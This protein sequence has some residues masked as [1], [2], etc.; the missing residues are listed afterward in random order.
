MNRFSICKN[1]RCRFVLDR[2]VNGESLENP[3]FLKKCPVCGSGWS[4]TCP[5]CNGALT[6]TFVGG[7]PHYACCGQKVHAEA[8]AA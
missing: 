8:K 7:L 2:G 1:P 5:S 4:S 3:Q 6:I